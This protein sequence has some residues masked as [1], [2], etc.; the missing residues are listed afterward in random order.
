MGIANAIRHLLIDQGNI[1]EAELARRM[2]AA[3]FKTSAQNFNNKMRRESF[4]RTELDKIAELFGAEYF[5]EHREGFRLK[6][7]K[8]IEG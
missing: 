8:V 6:D 2:D 4:S 5:V 7:G 3:G 1:S